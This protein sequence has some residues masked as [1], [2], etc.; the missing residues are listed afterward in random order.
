[1]SFTFDSRSRLYQVRHEI[2]FGWLCDFGQIATVYCAG[3]RC[4]YLGS[5]EQTLRQRFADGI[6]NLRL[7]RQKLHLIILQIAFDLV[8]V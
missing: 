2:Y 6:S 4:H 3:V 5:N 1:M 8:I 7:V